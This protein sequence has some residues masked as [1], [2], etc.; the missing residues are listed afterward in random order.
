M[1]DESKPA[2]ETPTTPQ[3]PQQQQQQAPVQIPVDIEHMRVHGIELDDYNFMSVPDNADKLLETLSPD[4][5][6][7]AS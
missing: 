1:A 7:N 4:A 3:A 2:S 5:S 6:A